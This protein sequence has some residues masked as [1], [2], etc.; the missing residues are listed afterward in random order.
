MKKKLYSELSNETLLKRRDFFEGV[1]IAFSIIYALVIGIFIYL[2]AV[3]GFKKLS[4]TAIMPVFFV[5]LAFAP[6]LIN[7][8]LILTEIKARNL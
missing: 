8:N 6:L 3:D 2:F 1:L 5:P 7:Y 4:V